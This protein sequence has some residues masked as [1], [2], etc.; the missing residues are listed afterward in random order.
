MLVN[1]QNSRSCVNSRRIIDIQ[2]HRYGWICQQCSGEE[3]VF[4]L[5]AQAIQFAQQQC[6]F[7]AAEI[8]LHDRR[9]AFERSLFLDP[10]PQ[11][12]SA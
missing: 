6:A 2:P 1:V 7:V 11:A 4:I 3:R 8:R 10:A 5:K 9:G 12:I